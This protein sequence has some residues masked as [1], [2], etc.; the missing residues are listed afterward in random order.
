MRNASGVGLFAAL[1][2]IP[3]T[4]LTI[5][6]TRLQLLGNELQTAKLNVLRD[7]SLVLAMVAFAGMGLVLAVVLALSLLWDQR[8]FV[9][10]FLSVLF[11]GL[12][13]AC[14]AMLRKSSLSPDGVFAASLAELQEDLRQLKAAAEHGQDPL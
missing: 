10:S 5:L 8:V 2:G 9:L 12:A 6:Q 11:I 1:K 14:Y 4:L 7:L 3:A 13:V